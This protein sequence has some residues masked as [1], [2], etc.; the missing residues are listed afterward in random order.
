MGLNRR[1]T[2]KMSSL[3]LAILALSMIPSFICAIYYGE[4]SCIAAF[5]LCA[6]VYGVFGFVFY[7]KLALTS[8]NIKIRDGYLVVAACWITAC[9][10]GAF[11]YYI[12]DNDLTFIQCIFESTAGITTTGSSILS[13]AGSANSLLLFK[14]I[15]HWIG[16]MVI[17]VL[18]VS[19]L[20]TLG[21]G[22]QTIANAETPTP[23]IEKVTNRMSDTAL[24]LYVMYIAFT[25]LEFVLLIMSSELTRFDAL[26]T[27][28]ST[29]STG[30][31]LTHDVGIMYY[32]SV[33]I[34]AIITIF[35]ILVAVNFNLYFYLV[36][37]RFREIIKSTELKAFL[38]II[39]VSTLIISLDVYT[40]GIYS[41]YSTALRHS[42]TQAVSFSS[43]SGFKFANFMTWPSLSKTILFILMMMGGCAAST[44]GGIKIVRIVVFFKLA[45]RG[46]VKRLHPRSVIAIKLGGN[47][48]DSNLVTQ[49]AT[50]IFTF[51]GVALASLLVISIEAPDMETAIGTVIGTLSNTGTIYGSGL[52]DLGFNYFSD[53]MKLYLSLMMIMGRL[54][55]FTILILFTRSFWNPDR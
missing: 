54:E 40:S 38:C 14:A 26:L 34:E 48:L 24:L 43:T 28:L 39:I 30:G 11:P 29:I 13:Q 27:T 42:L 32:N 16:G 12:A 53:P 47:S 51:I 9:F 2:V 21:I 15:C 49:M 6:A 5:G 4:K 23:R 31:F 25:I 36:S 45:M 44:S 52:G 18:M 3:V 37:G 50:F 35:S 22:G 10:F 33:Y 1:L 20:P 46:V 55:L 7:K 19:I 8:R 41:N 17:L